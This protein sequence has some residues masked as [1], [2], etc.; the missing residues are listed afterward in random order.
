MG[1]VL[2]S[3]SFLPAPCSLAAVHLQL[4]AHRELRQNQISANYIHNAAILPATLYAV[5]VS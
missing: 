2:M 4:T 5:P 1:A 3:P